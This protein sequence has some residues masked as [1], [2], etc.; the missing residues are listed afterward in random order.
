MVSPFVGFAQV[1]SGGTGCS[2]YY[3]VNLSGVVDV[4]GT[5]SWWTFETQFV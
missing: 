1:V 5:S 2:H 4:V 3:E